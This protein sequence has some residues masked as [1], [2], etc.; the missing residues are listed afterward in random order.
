MTTRILV[1]N[2]PNLGTLGTRQPEV[3]GTT[4]LAEVVAALTERA[5]GYGVALRCE[6]SNHEGALI[7]I[8]ESERG[9]AHG[10]IINPGGLSHTSVALLDALVN[11]DAPVI[12]V[13][14][15]NIHT[16]EK[17]RRRSLTAHASTAVVTGFG[18]HGYLLALDG[19]HTLLGATHQETT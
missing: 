13:H 7:D 19:L 17:F 3:Y 1:L 6:Q 14:V 2:G 4:T 16:R 15:S 10:C 8:L 12:E 9:T 5:G 18:A 11:F